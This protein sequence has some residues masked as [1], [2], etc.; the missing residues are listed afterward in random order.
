MAT[1][2]DFRVSVHGGRFGQLSGTL[3]KLTTKLFIKLHSDMRTALF[4]DVTQRVV[5]IP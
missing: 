5:I 3:T 1:D 4:L 2:A